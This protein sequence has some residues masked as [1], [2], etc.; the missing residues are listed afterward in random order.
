MA[1]IDAHDAVATFQSAG[2]YF[3]AAADGVGGDLA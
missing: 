3:R 1:L 2:T